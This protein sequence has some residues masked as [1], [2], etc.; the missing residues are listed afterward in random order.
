MNNAKAENII[1]K[2]AKAIG[3][4]SILVGLA[5]VKQLELDKEDRM[6]AQAYEIVNGSIETA[7]YKS[8]VA[9]MAKS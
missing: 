7:L 2:I 5:L 6:I 1:R 3:Q 4:E 8:Y 9:S